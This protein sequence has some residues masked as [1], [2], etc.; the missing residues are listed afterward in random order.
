MLKVISIFFRWHFSQLSLPN[1]TRGWVSVLPRRHLTLIG[2]R[3][4]FTWKIFSPPSAMKRSMEC[5]QWNL[6]NGTRE[7]LTSPSMLILKEIFVK[8]KRTITIECVNILVLDERANPKTVLSVV[9][10]YL[11][12][13]KYLFLVLLV[14][15]N[16]KLVF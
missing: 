12:N 11:L 7:I 9:F 1:A 15:V 8:Y 14:K 10:F 13:V 16:R 4:C 5:S 6:T 3:Q 2:N